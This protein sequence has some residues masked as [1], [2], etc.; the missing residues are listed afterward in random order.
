VVDFIHV[1][2]STKSTHK[3][4]KK[5]YCRISRKSLKDSFT[6]CYHDVFSSGQPSQIL[7]LYWTKCAL[8]FFVLVSCA[9][10]SWSYSDF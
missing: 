9:I 6:G 5:E 4:Y 2:I 3:L 8:A 7:N 10:L 1:I